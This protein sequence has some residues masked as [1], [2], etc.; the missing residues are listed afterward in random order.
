MEFK[1]APARAKRPSKAAQAI[2]I[3][4]VSPS[5]SNQ[6]EIK[7][8]KGESY[9]ITYSGRGPRKAKGTITESDYKYLEKR[10][11]ALPSEDTV[12]CPTALIAMKVGTK[13]RRVCSETGSKTAHQYRSIVRLLASIV[14]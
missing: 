1:I 6:A 8:D 5:G 3:V 12:W 13:V 7:K 4:V 2:E 10:I 11:L 9:T 14:E